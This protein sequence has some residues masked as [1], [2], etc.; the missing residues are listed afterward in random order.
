MCYGPVAHVASLAAMSV[1]RNF[2][3]HE[4]EGAD[5][6][7][8]QE[9]TNGTYPV[10]KDGYLTLP[11]KPGLGIEFDGAQ[12]AERFPFKNLGSQAGRR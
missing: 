5:D 9:A 3:I 10:Q 2:L 12:L 7:L 6:K 1:C 4:W 11:D 8:F